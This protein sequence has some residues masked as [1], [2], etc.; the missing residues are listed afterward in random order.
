VKL[1]TGVIALLFCLGVNAQHRCIVY[2]KDK[3]AVSSFY[4]SKEAA[5]RRANLGLTFDFT[6]LQVN[7]TY[8]DQLV[9][10]G[11]K[12][13]HV[14]KW[15]NAALLESKKALT[16]TYAFIG[17][18]EY[19]KKR[20]SYTS[21]LH[22]NDSSLYSEKNFIP[23]RA[24][25]LYDLGYTGKNVHIAVF[26]AGYKGVDSVA[27]FDKL[28]KENRLFFAQNLVGQGSVFQYSNH[29]TQVLS[30]MAGFIP[31]T[32]LGTAVDARYSLFVTED[33]SSETQAE[34]F[35]WAVAA[36]MADSLGVDIINSSLGY[37][38]FN[39]PAT[40]Y[41]QESLDG[42]TAIS[43]KAAVLAARKGILVVNSAG[44][45][46]AKAWQKI[47]APGDA[48]S[49]LTVGA[50][51]EDSVL[52]YFSS[53]GPTADGRIKPEVC[54]LGS[55]TALIN[56]RGGLVLGNGTSF[57]SPLIAGLC[58][59]VLQADPSMTNHKLRRLM[60]EVSDR[61]AKPDTIYGYG[62]PDMGRALDFIEKGKISLDRFTVFPN[63][64]S[65]ELRLSTGD[66]SGSVTI[67]LLNSI[68]QFVKT[69]T[70]E[71]KANQVVELNTLSESLN[72]AGTYFLRIKSSQGTQVK[73]VVMD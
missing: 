37:T 13:L 62:I 16:D 39:D 24:N 65:R 66:V 55:G 2:F 11:Y 8:L 71:A 58:A 59:S 15:L 54:A 56:E 67:D 12:I 5:E 43:T 30:V 44:N 73:A 68:G 25:Q 29:G 33:V 46:G 61:Y 14:S 64:T 3:P 47:S 32:F 31:D 21:R 51:N 19:L 36:E 28:R 23:H 17:S 69:V 48:D 7:Q 52:A 1:I 53:L 34:E 4:L 70:I 49:I 20:A 6:D 18:V 72:S 22:S 26:D 40:N 9:N 57:S 38:E 27:G 10:D 35:N 50:I 60:M 45:L 42:H 63:P 41:T